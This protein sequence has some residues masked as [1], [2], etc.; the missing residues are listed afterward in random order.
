MTL[1]ATLTGV[2][3]S[4]LRQEYQFQQNLYETQ[5]SLIRNF[6]D[7]QAQT[8]SQAILTNASG[9]RF[10]LPNRVVVS[11][12][13]DTMDVPPNQ[14]EQFVGHRLPFGTRNLCADLLEH[15][16]TLEHT[17]N[18]VFSVNGSL[19]RYNVARTMVHQMLPDGRSVRYRLMDG[20][21][22]PSQPEARIVPQPADESEPDRL[23][24][25]YPSAALAF[26]LPQWVAFD[27][28]DRLLTSTLEEARSYI[29]SL[30]NFLRV[31]HHAVTI[32]PYFVAD[33]TYQ[34][35]RTGILGQLVNQGRAMS[36]FET[37]EL[38]TA[39]RRRVQA[40]S[41]NRGFTI[42]LT[43]FDDQELA[44]KPYFV[45]I[46]PAGRIMFIPAFVVLA[47]RREYARIIQ[48]TRLNSSTRKH[49]LALLAMLEQAFL[50]QKEY[51]QL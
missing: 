27:E 4:N 14:R 51:N 6:L 46:V 5:P 34:R 16:R 18:P 47:M 36:R 48:D 41:L 15:F 33:E 24:V 8:I 11:G 20:D 10:S 38:I 3:V 50:T 32:D 17:T 13:A 7:Q 49:L 42:D 37:Q 23:Q 30:Q 2:P 31:L 19:L 45:E 21:E 44:M 22:I 26:F 9:V 12:G 25:P 29:A 28:R 1:T 39:M 40:N 43:Y 35:K